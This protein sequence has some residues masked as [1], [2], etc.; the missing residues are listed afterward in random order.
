MKRAGPRREK[1]PLA[2]YAIGSKPERET[3]GTEPGVPLPPPSV[4]RRERHGLPLLPD[5]EPGRLFQI[6]APL[7]RWGKNDVLL[8]RF[9]F[10]LLRLVAMRWIQHGDRM[11]SL[12]HRDQAG[13]QQFLSLGS[14]DLLVINENLCSGRRCFDAN[15]RGRISGPGQ[16]TG[17]RLD[18]RSFH[19]VPRRLLRGNISSAVGKS[20]KG[21]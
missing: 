6:A 20:S 13:A 7:H 4:D 8:T 11:G 14:L 15:C 16:A 3:I 9:H 1:D 12:G 18:S 2:L 10:D 21:S 5:L 19:G 17:S